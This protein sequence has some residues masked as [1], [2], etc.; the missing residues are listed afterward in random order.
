MALNSFFLTFIILMVLFIN[1][2]VLKPLNRMVELKEN[3]NIYYKFLELFYFSPAYIWPLTFWSDCILTAVHIINKLPSSILNNKSPFEMLFNHPPDYT[4]LK[5]FGCLAFASTITSNRTKFYSRSHKCIFI[6][7]PL[8]SKGYKL[9]DLTTRKTFISRNVK[10]YEMT[11][12]YKTKL[13]GNKSTSDTNTDYFYDYSTTF[14]EPF[15]ALNHTSHNNSENT[16][17]SS[18]FTDYMNNYI[19]DEVG[20]FQSNTADDS[21][22]FSETENA[23]TDLILTENAQTEDDSPRKSTRLRSI[24][25]HIRDFEYKLPRSIIPGNSE[26][27]CNFVKYPIQNYISYN[28]LSPSYHCFTASLSKLT[29]PKTYKQAIEFSEWQNAMNAEIKALEDNNTWILVDLPAN[30]HT[31]CSKWVF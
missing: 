28:R 24:P 30:Q 7:Y 20:L 4:H 18:S 16:T 3:I 5:V 11:F 12:P 10:F 1:Y 25:I 21:F 9:Y 29:E 22:S 31:I 17:L 8:G 23:Q 19:N 27:T 2:L 14:T 15:Q 6:G 26:S 13:T